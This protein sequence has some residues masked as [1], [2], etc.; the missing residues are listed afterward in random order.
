MSFHESFWVTVGTA[1]PII[2][3]AAIVSLPDVFQAGQHR[4]SALLPTIRH[5]RHVPLTKNTEMRWLELVDMASGQTRLLRRANVIGLGNGIPQ[6]IALWM[7]LRSLADGRNVV[8]PNIAVIIPPVGIFLPLL[9]TIMTLRVRSSSRKIS[10]FDFF[11]ESKIL[12][13][14]ELE[15][16]GEQEKPEVSG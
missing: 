16:S 4:F 12:G 10:D 15:I 8:S 6:L 7:A 9:G 14:P 2:A 1:A 11:Q 13:G 3:L 5:V